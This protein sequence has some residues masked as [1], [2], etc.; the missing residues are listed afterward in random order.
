MKFKNH[1]LILILLNTTLRQCFKYC[2]IFQRACRQVRLRTLTFTPKKNNGVFF[3]ILFLPTEIFFLLK[4]L[5]LSPIVCCL[6]PSPVYGKAEWQCIQCLIAAEIIGMSF[7]NVTVDSFRQQ[8]VFWNFVKQISL[9]ILNFSL[10]NFGTSRHT[11]FLSFILW[12][13][14]LVWIAFLLSVFT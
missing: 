8:C 6:L 4:I 7:S 9:F 14:I 13:W 3:N 11:P 1:F 2:N 5:S 10:A 12:I